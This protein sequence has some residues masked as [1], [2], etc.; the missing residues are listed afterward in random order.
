M[1][2]LDMLLTRRSVKRFAPDSLP[3]VADLQRIADAGANA[4]TGRGRQSPFI[5][6]VTDRTVRDELSRLNAAHALGWGACWIHRAHEMFDR[7]EGKAL[8]AQWGIDADVEGIGLC[9][10]GHAEHFPSHTPPRKEGYI[11]FV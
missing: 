5:V 9:V 6:V 3:S 4:P 8:L 11:R 1:E 10:V 2:A 7:P